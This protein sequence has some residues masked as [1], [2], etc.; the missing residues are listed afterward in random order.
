MTR[1]WLSRRED[2]VPNSLQLFSWETVFNTAADA[3]DYLSRQ[4]PSWFTV[5]CKLVGWGNG[6]FD[7]KLTLDEVLKDK[8]A[9]QN[10]HRRII[11]GFTTILNLEVR[12]FVLL[13][14]SVLTHI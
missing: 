10:C 2:V 5:K 3:L 11:S 8:E 1:L 7:T 9:W 14:Y 6:Q 4:N 12:I 13:P